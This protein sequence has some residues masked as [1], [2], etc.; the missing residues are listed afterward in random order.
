[1]RFYNILPGAYPNFLPRL[2]RGLVI[3]TVALYFILTGFHCYRRCIQ[4][5]T[6][7]QNLNKNVIHVSFITA[8]ARQFWL[9]VRLSVCLSFTLVN[10]QND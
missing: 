5:H 9:F 4:R 3:R 8:L 6:R 2:K 10:W 1:M 7:V